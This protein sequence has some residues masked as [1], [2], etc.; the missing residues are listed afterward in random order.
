MRM[1]TRLIEVC[2]ATRK[3][4]RSTRERE[5]AS[6]DARH[7]SPR[8]GL[9]RVEGDPLVLRRQGVSDH[10]AVG[11]A[12]GKD[13]RVPTQKQKIPHWDFP[14]PLYKQTLEKYE[15]QVPLKTLPVTLRWRAH[16][17][18]IQSAHTEFSFKLG[19]GIALTVLSHRI[20]QM[21]LFLNFSFICRLA[22]HR[23]LQRINAQRINAQSINALCVTLKFGT[24]F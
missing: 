18:L 12:F 7:G 19:F 5:T 2:S 3:N 6:G 17:F 23:Y 20:Y 10:T 8:H 9:L 11:V 1:T 22:T 4:K 14:H 16:K 24:L 13:V 21:A 15:Q